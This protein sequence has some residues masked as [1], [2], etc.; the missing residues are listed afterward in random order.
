MYS[1]R[2]WL[3]K[4]YTFVQYI[5]VYCLV[6]ISIHCQPP[7]FTHPFTGCF[8]LIPSVC[9]PAGT[10]HS[11]V[12]WATNSIGD[13]MF[14]TSNRGGRE[15]YT[16]PRNLTHGRTHLKD[17]EKTW[18]SI[19]AI[20]ATYRTGS[21]AKVPFIFWWKLKKNEQKYNNFNEMEG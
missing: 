13:C 20:A 10:W 2:T 16:Y 21:V 3:R 12:P 19:I 17:P 8:L 18:V 11:N 6:L 4:W 1:T 7:R 15:K 5:N 14:E 9:W